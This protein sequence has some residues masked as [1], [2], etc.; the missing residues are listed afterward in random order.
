MVTKNTSGWKVIESPHGWTGNCLCHS[1]TIL[2]TYDLGFTGII[3]YKSIV[4]EATYCLTNQV[5][6]W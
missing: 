4:Y 5:L 2:E 6:G 3:R 1:A